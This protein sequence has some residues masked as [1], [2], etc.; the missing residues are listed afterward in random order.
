MTVRVVSVVKNELQPHL[1]ETC[2]SGRNDAGYYKVADFN[3]SRSY[4]FQMN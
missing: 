1:K 4:L 3:W 2:I